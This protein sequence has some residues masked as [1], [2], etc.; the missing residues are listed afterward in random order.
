MTAYAVRCALLSNLANNK[1]MYRP[2]KVHAPE[3]G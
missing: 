2:F 3:A 1:G